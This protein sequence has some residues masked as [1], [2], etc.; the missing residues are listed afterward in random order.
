MWRHNANINMRPINPKFGT[1]GP[2]VSDPERHNVSRMRRLHI[3]PR[4]SDRT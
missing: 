1:V 2:S 4:F 3:E